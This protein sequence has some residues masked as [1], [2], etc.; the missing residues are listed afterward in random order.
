MNDER[1]AMNI[2]RLSLIVHRLLIVFR[3]ANGQWLDFP[4]SLHYLFR[5]AA[6]R[7]YIDSVIS[8][9]FGNDPDLLR[10]LYFALTGVSLPGD[11]PVVIN[12]LEGVLYMTLLNDV[13]FVA[14]DRLVVL[15]EHQSTINPNM[16]LRLLMYIA[17]VYEELTASKD[18]F[19]IKR[20]TIPRPEFIVLYNGSAPYP[21]E[22]SIRLSDAFA[23]VSSFGLAKGLPPQLELTVKVYNINL[24]QNADV[25]A[26]C[27]TLNEYS[28]FIAKAR[29]CGAERQ[30]AREEGLR[31][32]VQW[33]I[34]NNILKEFLTKH[35]A[36]VVG[37]LMRE[38]NLEEALASREKDALEIGIEKGMEEGR[39]RRNTE[40]LD[41]INSGYS[42]E[43]L[44]KT[45]T[46]TFTG[47]MG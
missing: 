15:I 32:A 41:L 2:Y 20:L 38:W 6:N 5:V 45:L 9:L 8:L 36:E 3:S 17:R 18:I 26:R 42:L 47:N 33:C 19:G 14:A 13:S 23:D 1:G 25:L 10:E 29:E 24:G 37:M 16:A 39:I 12:T 30:A 27:K 31:T 11:A 43:D 35:G 34:G 44:K 40:I 22:D 46:T 28:V 21:R 4:L 7:E